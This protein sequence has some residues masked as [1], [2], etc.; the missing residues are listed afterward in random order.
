MDKSVVA[1]LLAKS[2]STRLPGKNMLPYKGKPML[3]HN[4]EKCIEIFDRV[5]VSSDSEEILAFAESFGAI[6]IKRGETL[7]G[8]T[9]DIPVFQHAMRAMDRDG[10]V[11]AIIAVHVDTPDISVDTLLDIED[12]MMFG[13]DEVMTCHPMTHGDNYHDQHNKIK[14]SIRGLS[15]ERLLNYGDPYKPNPQILVVDDTI[16]IQTPEDYNRANG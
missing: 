15:R 2:K 5:Y 4:L 9:P 11:D 14:G 1:L 10:F 8:E 16:E 7:C 3:Q 13:A 12:L 6:G